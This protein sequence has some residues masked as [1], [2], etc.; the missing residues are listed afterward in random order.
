MA[1]C[2]VSRSASQCLYPGMEQHQAAPNQQQQSQEPSSTS[3]GAES[4]QAIGNAVLTAAAEAAENAAESAERSEVVVQAVT[5]AVS[6]AVTGTVAEAVTEAAPA[7]VTKAPTLEAAAGPPANTVADNSDG[8]VSSKAP[9]GPKSPA[10]AVASSPS[11]AHH[12]GQ[13]HCQIPITGQTRHAL[14]TTAHCFLCKGL[15][16]RCAHE[17]YL[18]TDCSVNSWPQA[19]LSLCGV[20]KHPVVSLY[21]IECGVTVHEQVWCHCA[22]VWCLYMIRCGVAVHDKV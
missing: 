18:L 3:H 13:L 15:R 21:M 20:T 6:E 4:A 14:Y 19:S 22:F 1:A 11:S 17:H 9:A 16:C 12:T 8:H 5:E 10:G 2:I 7:T